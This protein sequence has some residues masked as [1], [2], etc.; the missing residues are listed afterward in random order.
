MASAADAAPQRNHYTSA[1]PV[2][3]WYP[4]TWAAQ[5]QIQVSTNT[6]FAN[7]IEQIIGMDVSAYTTPTLDN[8]IYYWRIRAQNAAGIWGAWSAT[9][10]FL[11][12]VM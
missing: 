2:L 1:T 3:T 4:V 5:Y 7:P 6:N 8:G 12:D 11:V 10:S 9:D